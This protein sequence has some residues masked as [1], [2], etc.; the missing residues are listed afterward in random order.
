MLFVF[1]LVIAENY[2]NLWISLFLCI[3]FLLSIILKRYVF[4]TNTIFNIVFDIIQLLI[5]FVLVIKYLGYSSI[6]MMIILQIDVSIKY[7]KKIIIPVTV[8]SYLLYIIIFYLSPIINNQSIYFGIFIVIAC[9]LIMMLLFEIM[10]IQEIKFDYQEKINELVANRKK[11]RDLNLKL[12]NNNDE[13]NKVAILKER[14]RMSKQIHDTLGHVMTATIVQLNAAEILINKQPKNA[15]E[16]IKNAK[17]QTK[18][19]LNK[20][21]DTLAIIDED[22]IQ[23][24]DMIRSAIEKAKSSMDI[25]I[26]SQ[27]DIKGSVSLSVQNFILS[28][29]K[30]GITNGIRHGGATAFVFRLSNIDGNILFFLEDNGKG[31]IEI[32]NGYGLMSMEKQAMEFG[33]LI[34]T[35]SLTEVGFVLEIIIPSKEVII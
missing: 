17:E 29:L 9:F 26:I 23:F 13:I 34:K 24:D 16:K 14:N 11:L 35:H 6:I 8:I 5:I 33:G 31:C 2:S 30:E 21:K 15:L 10:K 4:Y 28:A 12:Q 20:I 19:G 27:I 22:N 3:F 1:G 18:E 7:K 32:K 25:H